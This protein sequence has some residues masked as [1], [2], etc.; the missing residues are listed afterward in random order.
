MRWAK[1][2]SIIDHN[3]LHGGYLHRLSHPAL[4]LYLFLVVVGDKDGMSFYGERAIMEILRLSEEELHQ[5]HLELLKEDLIDYRSSYWWVKNIRG[6]KNDGRFKRKDI[7]FTR[8]Y[9]DEFS[10]DRRADGD[11]AKKCI[12]DLSRKLGWK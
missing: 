7:V 5:A 9:E 6:G 2:Y 11:F 12:H 4:I 10:S 8:C 1:S 3:F